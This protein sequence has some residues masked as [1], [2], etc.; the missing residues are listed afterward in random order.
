MEH[1]GESI[2]AWLLDLRTDTENPQVHKKIFSLKT[3]R[4]DVPGLLRKASAIISEHT[5]DF[6]L[7][8]NKTSKTG[9]EIYNTLLLKWTLHQQSSQADSFTVTERQ[10]PFP[11]NIEQEGSTVW[12]PFIHLNHI[13]A[14]AHSKNNKA[15]NYLQVIL[16]PL[17]GGIAIGAP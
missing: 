15:W 8:L 7:P 6:K 5:D 1:T 14:G 3:E 17:K 11:K 16:I 13:V 10:T 12:N 2:S 9:D 4:G